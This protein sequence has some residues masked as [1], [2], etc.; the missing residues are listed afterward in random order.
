[1]D[2][3][4]K[5]DNEVSIIVVS[6]KETTLMDKPIKDASPKNKEL[7]I[8]EKVNIDTQ[9]DIESQKIVKYSSARSQLLRKFKTIACDDEMSYKINHWDDKK[10]VE[11]I[12]WQKMSAKWGAAHDVQTYILKIQIKRLFLITLILSSL[13]AFLGGLTSVYNIL[14]LNVTIAILNASIATLTIYTK[15]E[16]FE[17]KIIHHV[18][19]SKEYREIILQIQ[20][21]LSL[22]VDE[23][24][25]A[26]KFIY[27]VSSKM[28]ELDSKTNEDVMLIDVYNTFT[29]H[30]S[31]KRQTKFN[32]LCSILYCGVCYMTNHKLNKKSS[33]SLDDIENSD[34]FNTN[35]HISG[36]SHEQNKHFNQFYKKTNRLD[37]PPVLSKS[38]QDISSSFEEYTKNLDKK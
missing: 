35:V 25:D 37:T 23:R 10:E 34:I 9:T 38:M 30:N 16:N 4:R 28:L 1:M 12:K 2:V 22:D 7:S 32:Y 24:I 13:C 18:G 20:Q 5:S 31:F 3:D 15:T 19:S 11:L 21:Q 29:K 17:K 27:S 26:N 6:P 33:D 8:V 14:Y 36:L